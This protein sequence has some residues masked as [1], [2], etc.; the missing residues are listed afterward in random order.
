METKSN[1]PYHLTTNGNN[2]I[3]LR[4]GSKISYYNNDVST[5]NIKAVIYN[6]YF[7][8]DALI[9]QTKADLSPYNSDNQMVNYV[10]DYLSV[11]NKSYSIMPDEYI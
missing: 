3:T 9:E 7:S 5:N 6:I 10:P 4:N 1:L 8:Y 11:Y 2:F